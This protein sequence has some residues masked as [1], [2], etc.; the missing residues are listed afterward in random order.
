MPDIE[1]RTF[2][3]R[4]RGFIREGPVRGDVAGVR[5][6]VRNVHEVGL[7]FAQVRPQFGGIPA[8]VG[9]PPAREKRGQRQLGEDDEV[10]RARAQAVGEPRHMVTMAPSR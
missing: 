5:H 1:E 4:L 6:L 10:E 7:H 3:I 8:Q 2:D 9:V